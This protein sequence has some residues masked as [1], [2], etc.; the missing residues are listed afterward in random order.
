MFSHEKKSELHVL[1]AMIIL[2]VSLIRWTNEALKKLHV[3][4]IIKCFKEV[5]IEIWAA[6]PTCY[7]ISVF[8][9]VYKIMKPGK[10]HV[11]SIIKCFKEVK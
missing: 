6:C 11:K 9:K 4:S 2:S 7:D 3:K 1:Y 5:K 8:D 10:K